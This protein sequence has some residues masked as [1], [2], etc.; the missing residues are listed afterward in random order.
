MKFIKTASTNNLAQANRTVQQLKRE[1]CIERI[2]VSK[3]SADIMSSCEE[4]CQELP[5]IKT[6]Q[7]K[8]ICIL[9]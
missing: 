3:A 8:K 7:N 5:F 6:K 2:K 9:L 1:A 4:H